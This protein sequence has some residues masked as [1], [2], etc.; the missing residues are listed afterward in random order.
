MQMTVQQKPSFVFS[1]YIIFLVF[2][3]CI[4]T[5]WV[6]N[7]SC[8]GYNPKLCIL[9]SLFV[10]GNFITHKFVG[11]SFLCYLQ[12]STIVVWILFMCFGLGFLL[13][14]GE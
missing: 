6:W 11:A 9:K 13:F 2:P 7:I 5:N 4:S 1:S 12:V 3:T 14:V 10:I 8:L